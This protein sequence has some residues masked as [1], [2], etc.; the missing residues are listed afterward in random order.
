MRFIF[1]YI[2]ILFTAA[3]GVAA[4]DA[5]LFDAPWHVEQLNGVA[6]DSTGARAFILLR[7]GDGRTVSGNTGCNALSGTFTLNKDQLTFSDM[8]VTR[9]ACFGKNVEQLFLDALARITHYRL[10]NGKLIFTDGSGEVA[11]FYRQ[12]Q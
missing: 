7:S 6:V 9:R 8:A 4:P 2:L 1:L 12:A 5:L 3:C 11:V 10:V